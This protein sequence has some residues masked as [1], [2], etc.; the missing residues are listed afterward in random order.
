MN[1]IMKSL[2][3]ALVLV[4]TVSTLEAQVLKFGHINSQELMAA[5]PERDAAQAKIEAHATQLETQQKNMQ[6][7]LSKK[8]EEYLGLRDSYSDLIKATKEKELQELQQ[9]IQT[10]NQVA[11]QDLQKKEMELLK[12]IIEKVQKAIDEVGKENGF[13]YIFDLATRGVVYHSD[14]SIDV[15]TLIRKKLGLLN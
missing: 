9:R 5:L 15:T 1:Q 8:Y 11:Q 6:D 3:I 14:K 13:I 7:E 2:I 10:F 4:C 12:P